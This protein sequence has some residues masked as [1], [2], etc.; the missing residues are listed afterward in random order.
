MMNLGGQADFVSNRL[1]PNKLS[2]VE[3]LTEGVRAATGGPPVATIKG[4]FCLG[5]DTEVIF[6]KISEQCLAQSKHGKG[7]CEIEES[8]F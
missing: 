7:A 5:Y 4:A 2:S 6:G 3:V 8:I 1:I